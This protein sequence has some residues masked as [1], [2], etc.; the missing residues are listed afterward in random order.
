MLDYII[1]QK[2]PKT[3]S[4]C[5]IKKRIKDKHN[6]K[7]YLVYIDR[8]YHLPTDIQAKNFIKVNFEFKTKRRKK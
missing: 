2:G 8:K 7:T 5:T 3:F 1:V 4:V 6:L